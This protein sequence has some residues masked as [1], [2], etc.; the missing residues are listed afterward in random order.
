MS[1][2]NYLEEE[3]VS[4]LLWK[5]SLPAIAGMLAGACYNII[6]SIFVGQGVGMIALT[7]VTIAFPIMAFLMAIGMLIGIGAGALV[8]I[9]LGR[10]KQDEAEQILGNALMMA[11]LFIV[12]T[13]FVVLHFLDPLLVGVMGATPEV[14]PYAHKFVA[15]ILLAS[16]FQHIGFG[17]N[18]VVR[19]QGNPKTALATQILSAVVNIVLDYV[20]IFIFHWGIVGAALAT[21]IGQGCSAIWVLAFFLSGRGA[22]RL[23]L[24]C[25]RPRLSIMKRI[26][27]IGVAP[28]CMQL[29]MC[30]VMVVL[31]WLV[32]SLGGNIAVAVYG[33]VN[34]VLM[35]AIMPVVGISQGAQPIIGYNFGAGKPQRVVQTIRL[36]AKAASAVCIGSFCLAELFAGDIIRLFGG[37][38]DMVDLGSNGLRIFVAALPLIGIQIIGAN[39]FQAIGKAGYAIVF[40]LLRQIIVFVPTAYLMSRWLGLT[41]IWIAGPV[42]DL[43]SA[44]IT[45]MCMVYDL[46]LYLKH[47]P[48]QALLASPPH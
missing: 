22:L 31:N 47:S 16:V 32:L 5:F 10:Q 46:R 36:A 6:D 23:R 2:V 38:A 28:F 8:S 33:I 1:R 35:L 43:S 40:S 21:A 12:P 30:A 45:V 4:H 15:I 41:G 24:H 42:A 3:K 26:A 44:V 29:G 34:R 7:A 11:V 48:P 39:Y 19:A 13:V 37:G 14:L 27:A 9:S 17:L 18:N 20:F 25:L